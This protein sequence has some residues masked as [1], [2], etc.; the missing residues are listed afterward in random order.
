MTIEPTNIEDRLFAQLR[1]ATVQRLRAAARCDHGLCVLL[2]RQRVTCL[3]ELGARRTLA[4]RP[5]L[6]AA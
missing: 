5:V 2:H 1:T 6:S 4:R 3:A